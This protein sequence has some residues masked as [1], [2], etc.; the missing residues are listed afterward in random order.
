MRPA[1]HTTRPRHWYAEISPYGTNTISDADTLAR[2]DNMQDRNA[3]CSIDPEHRAPVT[4]E[5]VR[6]RYDVTAFDDPDR[7]DP[8]EQGMPATIHHRPS[9]QF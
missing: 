1:P 6:H 8:A 3:Y 5:E 9:Y 4:L 7:R 2:F